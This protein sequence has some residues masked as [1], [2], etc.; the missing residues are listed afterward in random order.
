MYFVANAPRPL[1]GDG[2]TSKKSV[3]NSGGGGGEEGGEYMKGGDRETV[4]RNEF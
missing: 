3:V 4:V 2:L 1:L